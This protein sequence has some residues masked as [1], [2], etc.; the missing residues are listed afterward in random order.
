VG[1]HAVS[2][3]ERRGLLSK[4]SFR[5]LDSDSHGCE[6]H[7]LATVLEYYTHSNLGKRIQD[8][9]GR[10]RQVR[11][12]EA[13]PPDSRHTVSYMEYHPFHVLS[14]ASHA[15]IHA[16]YPPQIPLNGRG[17]SRFFFA[18]STLFRRQGG[19]QLDDCLS[20]QSTPLVPRYL[21]DPLF[22]ESPASYQRPMLD[23]TFTGDWSIVVYLCTLLLTALF[24]HD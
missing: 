7:R 13:N 19:K 22:I 3:Q 12:D 17:E 23:F 15:R 16:P 4:R 18:L 20:K 21:G 8:Y 5:T 9:G 14:L 6:H 24:G 10:L 11:S 2:R 1:G